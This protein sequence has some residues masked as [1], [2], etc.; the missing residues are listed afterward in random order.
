MPGYP[1]D[2]DRCG[3]GTDHGCKGLVT[4]DAHIA[5]NVRT[6][7]S[8]GN[9]NNDNGHVMYHRTCCPCQVKAVAS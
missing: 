1:T 9:G 7:D 8:F 6:P 3:Y 2:I 4:E 5:L